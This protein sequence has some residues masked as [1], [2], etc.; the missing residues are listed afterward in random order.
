MSGLLLIS[1]LVLFLRFELACS[2]NCAIANE[3]STVTLSCSPG[4]V[5]SIMYASYGNGL[6]TCP[7][8]V[9]GDCNSANSLSIISAACLGS[10]SCTVNATITTFGDPCPGV[11]KKLMVVYECYGT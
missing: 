3:N 10:A 9:L 4:L 6:G 1:T 11:S 5:G 8:F 2:L 7:N